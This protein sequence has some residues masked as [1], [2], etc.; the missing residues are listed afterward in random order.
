MSTKIAI[1]KKNQADDIIIRGQD[2][3]LFDEIG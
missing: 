1:K 3:D 2:N